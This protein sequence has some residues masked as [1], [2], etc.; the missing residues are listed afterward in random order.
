MQIHLSV[1]SSNTEEIRPAYEM[2]SKKSVQASNHAVKRE[3]ETS[4]G[5][6]QEEEK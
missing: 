1:V 2:C 5:S 3:S 4:L 6:V